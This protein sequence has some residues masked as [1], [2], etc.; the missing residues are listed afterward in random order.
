MVRFITGKIP[1]YSAEEKAQLTKIVDALSAEAAL[2]TQKESDARDAAIIEEGKKL[3]A[4]DAL[5]CADCH[6]FHNDASG[7]GPDFTGYGSRAWLIDFLKNPAHDR[8]YGKKNDRM[9]AFG[10][11]GRLSARDFDLLI[12]WLRGETPN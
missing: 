4:S 2:P 9:P 11:T 5:E 7:D 3:Y 8:F 6:Q 1:A 12:R 10:K